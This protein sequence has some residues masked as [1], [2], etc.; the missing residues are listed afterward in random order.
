MT[1]AGRKAKNLALIG[2]SDIGGH[3]DALQVMV[4][5]GY[6]FVSHPFSGGFSVLDVSDPRQISVVAYVPAPAGTRTLHLQLAHGFLL[7]TNEADT[8][9]SARYRDQATYYGRQLGADAAS[10][11]DFAA[12]IRVYDVTQPAEPREVAFLALKGFGAHRIF[13]TGQAVA[14][15]SAMPPQFPDF[16]LVLADF[17]DPARPRELGRWWPKELEPGNGAEASRVG[18]HHAIMAGGLAYGAWR[19]GGLHIVDVTDPERPRHAGG[20]SPSAWGGGQTHTTLPLPGRGLVVAADEAVLERCAD[21]E[22]R[23]WLL[24]VADPA[25]P[26]VVGALPAPTESGYATA[27]GRFGPHNLHE[28]RPGSW[29]SETVVF[30]TYQNAGVRVYDIS[31]PERPAEIGFI[32]PPPPIRIVDPRSGGGS[33]VTQSTDIFVSA[34]G[35]VY[36]T[37]FNSGIAIAEF[38]G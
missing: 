13:W 37:D 11:L 24:D 14:T 23:I 30:A 36:V 6:A 2:H 10:G 20:L 5:G 32:V 38:R 31:E 29:V 28:N 3:L 16:I 9:Q 8:V 22:K 12:G 4:Q 33:L 34:E 15:V 26:R 27:G 1:P 19:D 18:L 21:G 35:L 17:S 7:V 25:A